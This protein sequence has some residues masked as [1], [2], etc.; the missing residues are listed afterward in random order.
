LTKKERVKK[1]I[2]HQKNHRLPHQIDFTWRMKKEFL[3]Y[4]SI[5]ESELTQLLGNHFLYIDT[6]KK[7]SLDGEKREKMKIIAKSRFWKLFNRY[8][9]LFT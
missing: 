6:H 1:A 3:H 5:P 8:S 2:S 9:Y 4:F 7:I